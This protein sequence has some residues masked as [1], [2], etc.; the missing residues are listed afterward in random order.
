MHEDF[1]SMNAMRRWLASLPAGA[2]FDGRG[3]ETSPL[4]RWAQ[5][6]SGAQTRVTFGTWVPDQGETHQRLAAWQRLF[7]KLEYHQRL[8]VR[9]CQRLISLI[10]RDIDSHGNP[11]DLDGEIAAYTRIYAELTR[12]LWLPRST[13]GSTPL[14]KRA[15]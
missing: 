14:R 11:L 1:I 12:R 3:W 2:T 13:T 4:A 9:L 7:S 6:N 8:D 5:H 15:A 10:E